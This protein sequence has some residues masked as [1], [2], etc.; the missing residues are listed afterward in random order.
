MKLC[1]ETSYKKHFLC[2]NNYNH[3]ETLKLYMKNML[4]FVVMEIIY[5]S[6]SLDSIIINRYHKSFPE[7][8]VINIVFI[9]CISKKMF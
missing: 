5:R 7:L 2:V 3:G 4:G 6:K 8:L 1:M 9:I